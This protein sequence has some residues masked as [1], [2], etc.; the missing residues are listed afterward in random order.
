L[1]IETRC[2][3]LRTNTCLGIGT[4]PVIAR[5]RARKHR[6]E[7]EG[8]ERERVKNEVEVQKRKHRNMHG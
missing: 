1:L 2:L 6:I 5:E 7:R 3:H 8:E 4:A